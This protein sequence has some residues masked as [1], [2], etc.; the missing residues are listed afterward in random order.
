MQIKRQT[1][2]GAT[3]VSVMLLTV[4]L[5]TVG[6]LVM[7]S[8]HRE[9]TEAGALVARERAMMS[10]QAA[11]DLAAA[12]IREELRN[13][14]GDP[15][16]WLDPQFSGYAPQAAPEVCDDPFKDC[17]PGQGADVPLTGQK[18]QLLTNKSDCSGR[19]CMRQGAVVRLP[20]AD[21]NEVDWAQVPMADLLDNADPEA[22]VTVWIRNN[23]S[24]VLG[25]NA[26]GTWLNDADGRIV[27]TAMATLRNTTV[28]IEQELVVAPGQVAVPWQMQSP[29]L[30]YGGGHN[31][32]N[33]TV[34]V[35]REN[36]AKIP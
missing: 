25:E 35:C 8:S 3:M 9:V 22:R 26:V 5:L 31:N 18:N 19:P 20:D 11:I 24:D 10:A 21:L 36:Y 28:A 27:L 16:S 29:D 2:R 30:A 1:Q 17:I 32:D 4:S 13:T 23:T 15:A 34:D 6:V 33:A 12:H 14:G 7:K